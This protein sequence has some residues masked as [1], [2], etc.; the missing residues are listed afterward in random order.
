MRRLL[1]IAVS[2]LIL[3]LLWHAVDIRAIASAMGAAQPAWLAAGLACVVPLTAVTAWR[4]CLLSR[5]DLPLAASIR[6]ALAAST[7]NMVLPSKMGDLAKAWVLHKR[8]GFDGGAALALVV[9]E[10]TID[11]AALLAWGVLALCLVADHPAMLAAAAALALLL[12]MLMLALSPLRLVPDLMRRGARWL[13]PRA[14]R[15]AD[16]F[17]RQW[18]LLAAWFW[19]D[20]GRAGFIGLISGALWAGH[21][22]QIWLF[23]RTLGP[24]VPLAG[25]MAG[26]TLA[27]LAGLL[28]F[29][30]AGIGT[31]DAALVI[32]FARWLSPAQGAALGVLATSRYLIPALAGLLFVRDYWEARQ[33]SATLRRA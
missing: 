21:L 3:A 14:H 1:S 11:M 9:F 12:G 29:T 28:P 4:F 10:K 26:A 5:T 6:L 32:L 18:A 13:P 24:H 15:A 31:R 30:M 2:L 8:Y 19:A 7:L 25:S 27:I 17:A 16:D 22:V 23:A 33:A 20:R